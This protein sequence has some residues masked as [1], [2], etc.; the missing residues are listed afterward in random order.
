[1]AD[2]ETTAAPP[3]GNSPGPRGSAAE[4]KGSAARPDI[5]RDD[6]DEGGE[7]G[8]DDGA[9]APPRSGK[10]SYARA[11]DKARASLGMGQD[12][13]RRES[14]GPAAPK[15]GAKPAPKPAAKPAPVRFASD[16][17]AE[18]EEI[19]EQGESEDAD[20][21]GREIDD[22]EGEGGEGGG[23]VDELEDEL[24]EEQGA[25]GEAEEGAEGEEPDP[26]LVVTLAGRRDGEE[27]T[28]VAENKEDADLLRQL[29]NSRENLVEAERLRDEADNFRIQ[30]V[31]DRLKIESDPLG[32]L[33]EHM[34][35][36]PD[37]AL[38]IKYAITRGTGQVLDAPAR[39]DGMTLREWLTGLMETPA[40]FAVEKKLADSDRTTHATAAKKRAEYNAYIQTNAIRVTTAAGK[41]LKQM[42]P[43]AIVK[44][45]V[46]FGRFYNLVVDEIQ[47]ISEA[48]K[49]LIDPKETGKIV[50]SQLAFF[51]MAPKRAAAA[52]ADGD[53]KRRDRKPLT[54]T[55]RTA[56]ELKDLSSRRK[57]AAGAPQ[58]AGSP[59]AGLPHIPKSKN[60]E[61]AKGAIKRAFRILRRHMKSQAPR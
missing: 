6:D 10:A 30:S 59:V 21:G 19:D 29:G 28:L 25:G 40:A 14:K 50:E 51:G 48:E 26:E 15:A 24:G 55:R 11:F 60:R 33:M 61:E 7:G 44:D 12:G 46:K 41:A 54:P 9:A 13:V 37:L 5:P 42:A 38:V 22:D 43:A 52:T 18:G 35:T 34:K 36:A 1:M 49:R 2:D 58:G 23:A 8:E 39:E 17:P 47:R 32:Y 57:K 4:P 53:G 16:D 31:G 45:P 27:V 56:A 3:R 20:L